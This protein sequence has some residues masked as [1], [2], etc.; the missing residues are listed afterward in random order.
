MST[1]M[2]RANAETLGRSD[3]HEVSCSL[4]MHLEGAEEYQGSRISDLACDE[5]IE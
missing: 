4:S 1:T 3:V 2:T 5:T